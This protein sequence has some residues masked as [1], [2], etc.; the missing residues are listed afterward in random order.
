MLECCS[1]MLIRVKI[2][3]YRTNI[4][5]FIERNVYLCIGKTEQ[6]DENVSSKWQYGPDNRH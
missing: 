3:R 5:P 6:K 1:E 2:W 4:H